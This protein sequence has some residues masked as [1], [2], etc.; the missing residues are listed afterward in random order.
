MK[1]ELTSL[2]LFLSLMISSCN[3]SSEEATFLGQKISV[4]AAVNAV[5]DTAGLTRSTDVNTFDTGDVIYVGKLS[6]ID[7][8][9]QTPVAYTYNGT[10][11]TGSLLWDYTRETLYA[12]KRGDGGGTLT[13]DYTVKS[14]QSVLAGENKGLINSDFLFST[15]KLTYYSSGTT[16]TLSNFVHKVS[17][18]VVNID[19]DDDALLT[20]C[21]LGGG[22]LIMSGTVADDGTITAGEEKNGT[23]Q[24]YHRSGTKSFEAFVIP[25]TT[26]TE[27]VDF[28]TFVYNN[29][30][31]RYLLRNALTFTA[32]TYHTIN[33]TTLTDVPNLPKLHPN[34]VT[35]DHIGWVLCH[36]GSIYENVDIAQTIYGYA[37]NQ[38]IGMIGY[39]GTELGG[40]HGIIVAFQDA[41]TDNDR[42]YNSVPY[43]NS[44]W[45]AVYSGMT[46]G[47][48]VPLGAWTVFTEAQWKTLMKQCS[49]A[50]VNRHGVTNDLNV[51][52]NSD[53]P[54]AMWALLK[55]CLGSYGDPGPTALAKGGQHWVNQRRPTSTDLDYNAY[56][57]L[58]WTATYF[59]ATGWAT[60]S[61]RW[62]KWDYD[63]YYEYFRWDANNT[64]QSYAVRAV[65]TF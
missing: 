33:I 53:T 26:N 13:D 34:N 37:S 38:L 17:K 48:L 28:I 29:K 18:V 61:D 9:R 31:Y 12:F 14:D 59:T 47:S 54:V 11:F 5:S 41:G 30:T 3:T 25:Q 58:T 15:E 65:R 7:A 4:I 46:S 16:A 21:T 2:V 39:V 6:H 22:T 40:T 52:A 43:N 49:T 8:T 32:G 62:Y 36:D 24:M 20:S 10:E 19:C 42:V 45:V 55:E 60:C 35:T 51:T 63:D 64:A 56:P 50:Y 27:I 44:R 57:E 23:I 1:N